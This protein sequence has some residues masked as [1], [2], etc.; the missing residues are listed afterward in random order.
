MSGVDQ[1]GGLND[2]TPILAAYEI[3]V[4]RMGETAMRRRFE[5]SARRLLTNIFRTGLFEDPYLSP[6]ETRSVVGCAAHMQAGYEAQLR[7]IVMLKNSHH[8]LPLNRRTKVYIPVVD[9]PEQKDFLHGNV[10]ASSGPCLD[11]A[12]VGKYFEMVDDPAQADAA[13]CF[14]HA[15]GGMGFVNNPGYSDADRASGGNGYVPVS[16]QY[17]PYTAEHAR[18][19][20]IAG[21]DSQEDTVNRSYRGK[22]T[23]CDNEFELDLLLETRRRM[24]GKPVILLLKTGTPLVMQEVEPLADAILLEFGDLNQAALEIAGGGCEPSA[25]LPMQMPADMRTVEEHC[26]DVPFDLRCHVDTDG[27]VYDFAYGMNWSGVIDDERVARFR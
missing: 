5:T 12:L 27:H 1:F 25:L 15:P 9:V 7:S 19:V 14:I 23:L 4:Q 6:D 2:K 11:P 21:G 24:G 3:G 20:S 13:L 18:A 26:E 10:P 8:V 17:R 22:T 16:L